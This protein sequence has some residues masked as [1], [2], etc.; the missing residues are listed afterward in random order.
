LVSHEERGIVVITEVENG[1]KLSGL[2]LASGERHNKDCGV[3]L[4]G[5]DVSWLRSELAKV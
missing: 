1:N 4:V 5:F 2:F 3:A